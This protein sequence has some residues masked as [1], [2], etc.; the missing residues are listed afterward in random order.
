MIWAPVL[1]WAG[2]A[3]GHRIGGLR[4]AL[5]WIGDRIFWLVL[6]GIAVIALRQFWLSTIAKRAARG[7]ER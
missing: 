4:V 2:A 3:L 5:E 1:L 6:A 7:P